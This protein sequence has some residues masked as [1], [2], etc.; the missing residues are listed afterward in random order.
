MKPVEEIIAG[1]KFAI[2]KALEGRIVTVDGIKSVVTGGKYKLC[3][4][5]VNLCLKDEEFLANLLKTSLIPVYFRQ[6]ENADENAALNWIMR[7]P[8]NARTTQLMWSY[9]RYMQDQM[10]HT[11][12]VAGD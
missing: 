7:Y 8:T 11:Q 10:K 3:F 5:E 4:G 12:A 9:W 2:I 6:P 1:G